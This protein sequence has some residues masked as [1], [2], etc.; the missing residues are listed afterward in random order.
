M[1]RLLTKV[2]FPNCLLISTLKNKLGGSIP[3]TPESFTEIYESYFSGADDRAALGYFDKDEL[4]SFVCI[5]FHESKMRG[6]F[7][8]IAAMYTKKFKNYFTFTTPE[9]GSLIKSAFD[10]AESK[11]YYEYY[12]C[13]SERVS[14]VYERQWD[15]NPFQALG[16]YDK[17]IL[18]IVP[19]NTKPEFE[20]SWRMMGSETKPDTF[21]FKKRVLKHEFRRE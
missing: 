2:D 14:R 15:K 8:I 6:Q 20:L 17:E 21:I 18:Y 3:L 19:P 12:Y 13:T 16:R 5:S 7:W 9:L 10:F 4:I 11:G 1:I